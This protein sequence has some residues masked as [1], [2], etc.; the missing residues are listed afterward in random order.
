M[1]IQPLRHADKYCTLRDGEIGYPHVEYRFSLST[2]RSVQGRLRV[3]AGTQLLD[4]HSRY[5]NKNVNR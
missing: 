3:Q 1:Q 4:R 2:G 5:M